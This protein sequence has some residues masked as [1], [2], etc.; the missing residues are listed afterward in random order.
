MG[1]SQ[2]NGLAEVTVK[3]VQK[4]IRKLKNQ[5]ENDC[6][7]KIE[8][9]SPVWP[10]LVRYAGQVIHTFKIHK[11]DGRTSRERIRGNPSIPII[12]KFGESVYYKPAK[13][14]K[15]PKAENRWNEG[16]WLGFI[17]KTNEHI[18]GTQKGIVKCWAIKR[19]DETE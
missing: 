1:E 14:I 2:C 13:T 8:P 9:E 17:D 7:Q 12:P 19:K 18:I 16:I 5:L 15:I 11:I 3:E 10:W 6:T 4:Q